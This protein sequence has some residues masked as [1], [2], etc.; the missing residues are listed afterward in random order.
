[1]LNSPQQLSAQC[2][3]LMASDTILHKQVGG[4]ILFG[5]SRISR[6]AER[7]R[8]PVEQME[9][10]WI[11]SSTHS[12][13]WSRA[14]TVKPAVAEPTTVWGQVRDVLG[15]KHKPCIMQRMQHYSFSKELQRKAQQRLAAR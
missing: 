1:M 2:L 9:A 15:L 4:H 13:D 7:A 3:S 14:S 6:S 10:R 5:G 12:G 11:G 8:K